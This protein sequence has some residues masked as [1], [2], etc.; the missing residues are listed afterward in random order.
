MLASKQALQQE[1]ADGVAVGQAPPLMQPGMMMQPGMQ[2]PGGINM[3]MQAQPM[4]IAGPPGTISMMPNPLG[5]G[6]VPM[7]I[8]SDPKI[9]CE[10]DDCQLVGTT[11]CSW[12]N[13]AWR[14]PFIGGCKKRFCYNH[15]HERTYVTHGK[16]RSF[17]TVILTCRDCG[18]DCMK[19]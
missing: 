2:Q 8:A 10:I 12:T 17:T 19:D 11:I 9:K 18:D 1:I 13:C 5:A 16:H 14:E 15:R 4:A 7:A 3:M 6:S